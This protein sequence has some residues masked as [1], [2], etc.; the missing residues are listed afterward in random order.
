MVGTEYNIGVIS[1]YVADSLNEIG[2]AHF[3]ALAWLL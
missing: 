3:D 2:Q 1:Y